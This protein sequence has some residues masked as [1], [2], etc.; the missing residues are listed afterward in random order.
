MHTYVLLSLTLLLA[1]QALGSGSYL[2]NRADP[3]AHDTEYDLG[4]AIFVGDVSLGSGRS[5]AECHNGSNS[6]KSGSL[7]KMSLRINTQIQKCVTEPDRGNG[8]IDDTQMEALRRF[9]F[10]RYRLKP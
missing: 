4:K 2:P 3:Y 6:L 5:C 10:R 8:S 9:L 1:A 7:R